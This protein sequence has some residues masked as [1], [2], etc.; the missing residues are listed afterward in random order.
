MYFE[1]KLLNTSAVISINLWSMLIFTCEYS[2]SRPALNPFTII[3]QRQ[4][5][6]N[7]KTIVPTAR[8]KFERD[9]GWDCLVHAS[10]PMY[11]AAMKRFSMG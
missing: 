2:L 6:T 8:V 5:N 4:S 1:K 11:M 3:L 10:T 9:P 7:P